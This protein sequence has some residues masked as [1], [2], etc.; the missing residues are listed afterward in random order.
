MSLHVEQASFRG[1]YVQAFGNNLAQL[2]DG[3]Y[4]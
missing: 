2:P 4:F 1:P 3:W